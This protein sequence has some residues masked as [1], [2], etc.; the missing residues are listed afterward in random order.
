[1]ATSGEESKEAVILRRNFDALGQ[2]IVSPLSTA[3][4]LY[5]KGLIDRKTR[6]DAGLMAV[7]NHDKS[8]ALVR[9][10][11]S[12]VKYQ[13][14][15]FEVFLDAL[16]DQEVAYG[17][18][19]KIREQLKS[20]KE[21]NTL[22]P[23]EPPADPPTKVTKRVTGRTMDKDPDDTSTEVG[24]PPVD[25]VVDDEKIN[26]YSYWPVVRG[27]GG[28]I[29]ISLMMWAV[30]MFFY[31]TPGIERERERERQAVVIKQLF[32]IIKIMICWP[33]NIILLLQKFLPAA[34]INLKMHIIIYF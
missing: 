20:A 22:P 1:M 31:Q 29:V 3:S 30:M 18:V 26:P 24:S 28:V 27:V 21:E 10:I 34:V 13:P 8:F 2:T 17:L 7:S 6:D 9:A 15:K 23:T 4:L 14:D 32:I 5:S 25:D 16:E 12:L 19:K 11:E 33:I